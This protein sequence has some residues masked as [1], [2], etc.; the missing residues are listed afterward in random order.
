M[1]PLQQWYARKMNA[2]ENQLAFR[3]TNRVVRPFEWGLEW[4]REWPAARRLPRNGHDPEQY[5]RLMNAEAIRDSQEFFSYQTPRDFRLEGEMLSFASPVPSPYPENDTVWGRYF[6]G[7]RKAGRPPVRKAVIV[8]PH[9]NASAEQHAALCKGIAML[10]ISAVRLSLPYHDRRMPPELERAD[11]AV[12]SNIGRTIEAT[13]QAVIDVRA[14]AD[15]L[16]SRGYEEIG[17]CGT[18]LGSCYAFMASAHDARFRVNVF[19]HCSTLFADVIWEGL[20]T[21]HI[22]QGIEDHIDLDRLRAV[23]DVVSPV[24]YLDRFAALTKRSLFIYTTYDTTFPL[25]FSKMV[26]EHVTARKLD[27]KIVQLPCGH[28]TMGESP[29]KFLDGYQICSFLKREL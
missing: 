17:I 8:L 12:S 1:N 24:H 2:W 27:C 26:V 16:G 9:W 20:S 29:F 10:G 21:Q 3:S 22:R 6:P 25:K 15:W 23:W 19:N 7:R 5:L 14:M 13:R 4:A 18:S 28:Y 11:Y